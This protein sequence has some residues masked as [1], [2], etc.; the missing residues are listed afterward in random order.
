MEKAVA[1]SRFFYHGKIPASKSLMNRALLVKSFFPEIKISGESDCEDVRQ[2]QKA[3]QNLSADLFDCKDAGTVLRFLTFR[4]SREKGQFCLR[5]S[6]RLFSRPQ[7]EMLEILSQLGVTCHL[8][9]NQLLV[10]SQGWQKPLQTLLVNRQKSSQFAT[11]LLLSC[12]NL[13]FDLRF[14]LFPKQQDDSYWQMT[15]EFA[16]SLGM[17]IHQS[18]EGFLIPAGQFCRQH[19]IDIEP[20]QSSAFALAA[21]AA[22]CGEAQFTTFSQT[23]IQP[24]FA[25]I[26]LLEKMQVPLQWSGTNLKIQQTKKFLPVET[27]MDSTPDLFPVLAVICAF[28]EGTSALGI[29]QRLIYKESNRLAKTLELLQLMK[30]R[31]ETKN[32]VLHIHGEG[33]ALKDMKQE[34]VFNPDEDHRMAMAAGLLKKLDWPVKILFSHVVDKS[35]PEFWR[36]LEATP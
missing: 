36:I 15:L 30:V 26:D 6:D 32:S 3:T 10:N 24:D 27:A 23:S 16:K 35:F 33:Q 5:G 18:N 19:E 21:S 11:G 2:M 34:F 1:M 31:V 20:D 28:A 29:P 9:D 7:G 4:L 14:E 25:F 17:E 22:L 8:Q 12:W 13:P